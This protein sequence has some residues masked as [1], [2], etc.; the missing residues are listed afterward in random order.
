VTD[1]SGRRRGSALLKGLTYLMFAMF[2]MTTDSVGV[3]IPQ[4]IRQ[5]SLGMTA[6][7]AF[8]YATMAG[9]SLAALCL[10]FFADRFGRQRT[11]VLGLVL[12]ALTC[13]LF[14]VG[15]Q[16]LFFVA[17]LFLGGI[18]IGVFKAGALALIGDLSGSTREH[19]ST[20]NALEGFFGVGAIIG[21][22]IVASL[23]K[24]GAG[25]QWLYVIAAGLC[26]ILI[27]GAMA[28]R[29]PASPSVATREAGPKEILTI[30]RDRDGIAFGTAMALYVGAEAAVYVW[31]PTYLLGYRGPMAWLALYSVSIFFVLRAVG[32]FVGAFMMA[33]LNWASVLA[34][35]CGGVFVCFAFASIGGRA[36]AVVAL[37]L[38]GIF[39]SVIYPTLNSKGISCFEKA[40][41]GAA[42]GLLLFFTCLSAVLSP[43]AMAALS[44]SLGDARFGLYLACAMTA[45]LAAMA[46]ANRWL[47][48]MGARLAARDDEDYA[49]VM[50][51]KAAGV[52][53]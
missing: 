29:Y 14:A 21:P 42:A 13:G 44:D 36:V 32:R 6:A 47:D 19:T 10:G 46:V 15:H 37:P 41:H 26:G 30:F 48:P 8:Q 11:I 23:L 53:G 18:G 28:G 34:I 33:R 40:R 38:S 51:A 24:V 50:G 16:F 52:Q 43:L 20:M 2:A 49:A 25:W 31:L 7:G 4:I 45:G 12:Y 1:T 5:F 39:M 9:I 22:A 27:I 3:I 17:L 35:A